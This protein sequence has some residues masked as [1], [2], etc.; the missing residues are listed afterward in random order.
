MILISF[1]ILHPCNSLNTVS[2][3]VHTEESF[4]FH[5]SLGH[6]CSE[7]FFLI[8]YQLMNNKHKAKITTYTTDLK[9]VE[10]IHS[11]S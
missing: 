3:T 4:H 11:E 5:D 9:G 10:V 2:C 7:N 1:P 8:I 6:A